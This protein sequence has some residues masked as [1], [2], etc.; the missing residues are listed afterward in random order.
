MTIS[1]SSISRNSGGGVINGGNM[2]FSNSTISSNDGSGFQNNMTGTVLL[3]NSTI[4]GNK[5]K[6]GSGI[7]NLGSMTLTNVTLSGNHSTQNSSTIANKGKL[8]LS[9]STLSGNTAI[10]IQNSSRG[11]IT[12]SNSI[13]ANSKIGGVA[14]DCIN[15]GIFILEG[16]NLI[17][18][19]SCGAPLSGDPKLAPLFDNGGYTSTYA[20]LA[21][22][23]A[24]NAADK[25]YCVA[26]DQRNVL[27]PLLTGGECDLGA[28]ERRDGIP[29]S[30]AP[31]MQFFDQQVEI[32]AITGLGTQAAGNRLEAVRNQLFV[33]GHYKNR[34]KSSAACTQ[35]ARTVKRI[36]PDN[37]PDGNDLVTGS[38]AGQLVDQVLALR[39]DWLCE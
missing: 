24:L 21:D 34:N 38:A 29:V 39:T 20:L 25:N 12:L 28:F 9:H 10:G 13:I 26:I 1:S 19:G 4:V 33:S 5:A 36:D 3:T 15:E 31:V 8:K 37:S 7:S 35:L 27:R 22:S 11:E 17:E 16:N 23:P 32:G 18:D 2:T 30:V 14:D 6:A